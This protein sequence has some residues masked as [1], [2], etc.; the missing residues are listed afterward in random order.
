M[1]SW[2]LVLF[3]WKSPDVRHWAR[4]LT[5]H[6]HPG[7]QEVCVSGCWLTPVCVRICQSRASLAVIASTTWQS[8]AP[9]FGF[10]QCPARVYWLKDSEV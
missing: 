10:A 4:G 2:R 6:A 7:A 3:L 9:P 8:H 5:P 1:V